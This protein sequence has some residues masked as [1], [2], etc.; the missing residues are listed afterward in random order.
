VLRDYVL[1]LGRFSRP[2][3]LFLAAQF[4][5]GVGQTAVWVLRNLYLKAS[6]FDEEFIGWTLAVQSLGMAA[7]VLAAT[8]FM[9]R[10]R[11][12][13]FQAAGVLA[14]AAGLVGVTLTGSRPALL[15]ICFLTGLGI[16]LLDVGSAPFL[17][18]H[19]SR[20]ERPYLFG[21]ATALSPTSGLVATLGIKAGAL[22]WGEHGA[23]YA[24]MLLAAAVVSTLSLAA[25]ALVR[26]APP[27]PPPE[28]GDRFD[29]PTAFRFFLPELAFGLGAGLTIPFINLYFRNRFHVPAGDV[30]LYYAAAQ[31][32][33]M[34]AFL[35][36]PVLARRLG[37]VRTIVLFQLTSIP[38]FLV[39]A[40]T[41]SLPV[42]IAAFLLRHACMN[43]V[44][45]V[46]AHFA[47]EVIHPGQR[48]RVNG[49]KQA[50]NKVSWVAANFAGGF[51]VGQGSLFAFSVD[52]FT[53]TMLATIVLYVVGSA[54]YWRYFG[55]EP[56]GR[57]PAPEG[58]PAAGP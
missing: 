27:E 14:L 29:W 39:L 2:A 38:F 36:A 48:A 34:V 41:T 58:E 43:M 15:G 18:R 22:A 13:P 33:M 21:V 57:V 28:R 1:H 4:L 49:L 26:E 19:S 10:M 55:R 51:L 32:L 3:R 37:P 23:A 47:M 11:F 50:A 54:M 46:G 17:V 5:Y 53:T 42:A 56:A 7:V 6:G 12:R 25:L 31:G 24:R 30:G 16:A 44:H 35:A 20:G 9:D 8:P 45:P 40:F 52:G